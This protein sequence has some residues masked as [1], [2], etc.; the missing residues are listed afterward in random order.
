[1][2]PDV[3]PNGSVP[4]LM[5]VEDIAARLRIKPRTVNKLVRERRLSCVQV[6]P[7]ERRFLP[8]HLQAFIASRTIEPP[9][10]VDAPRP[11]PLTSSPKTAKPGEVIGERES[12]KGAIIRELRS[13]R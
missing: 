3:Q 6:T 8:E 12:D 1:M 5:T 11:I 10:M 7:R 9:K 4:G 13:W 2:S